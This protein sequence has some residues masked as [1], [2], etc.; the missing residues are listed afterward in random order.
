M[1]KEV[2]AMLNRKYFPFERNSYYFGKLLATKDFEDEQ[3]YFNDKR[4]FINR[5]NG[6]NGVLSG[7]GVI[8]A[9]DK[10][11]VIQAGCA[12]DAS[13]R[14]IIIPETK[15]HKLSTIEGFDALTSDVAYLGVVYNEKPT[16]EVYSVLSQSEDASSI[17]HNKIVEDYRLV[18]M[19]EA[20]VGKIENPLDE[21]ITKILMFSDN[22]ITV[23]QYIPKYVPVGRDVCVKMTI[24]KHTHGYAEVSCC[25]Q[26]H[27][28]GFDTVSGEGSLDI[29]VNK[30]QLGYNDEKSFTY[31]IKP[32]QHIWGGDSSVTFEVSDFSIQKDESVI[33]IND[34]FACKLKPV[35]TDITSQYL[36]NYYGKSMDKVLKDS[37][38]EHLWIAKI[39]LLRQGTSVLIDTV[40][41][42]PFNQYCYNAQ[43]LMHL[44]SLEEYHPLPTDV[45]V[46]HTNDIVASHSDNRNFGMDT[47][48]N[49]ASGVAEIGLGLGYSTKESIFSDEIMHGLGKGAV[50][51]EVG[52]E[53]ITKSSEDVN[54]SEIILG[55]YKIFADNTQNGNE[56]VYK[57][58]TAIKVL[59]ERGTFVVGVK[60]A[61]SSGLISLRIRWYAFKMNE[62]NKKISHNKKDGGYIVINPD[63]IV[64]TPKST[65]HI[66]PVFV[67]M[68]T[69]ACAYSLVDPEGGTVDNNG[70]YTASSKEGVYEVKVSAIS[71]PAIYAH[72]FVIVSQTK[73]D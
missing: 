13:G 36:A 52:I 53:Y 7:F 32:Q 47:T 4:R 22:D 46:S 26:L 70:V 28:P 27:V 41:G 25:Y 50:Y 19:D 35:K 18:V 11:I 65:T 48:K 49:T 42:L 1:K 33:P 14:E 51:V 8:M 63:T 59:P 54:S 9:D 37:Y 68:P 34:N 69:E 67:N 30:L 16:E 2:F 31:Y 23:T 15:V 62:V 12:I 5:L 64:L 3:K 43:Q 17:C 71:N 58:S 72:A 57:A 61:E 38:D 39:N 44:R 55:D 66:T 40:E 24:K 10:A 20:L 45:T 56:R 29:V 21:Y 6:A 60:L 73:K